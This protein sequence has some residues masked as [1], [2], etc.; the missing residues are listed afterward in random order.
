MSE[1]SEDSSSSAKSLYLPLP[2]EIVLHIITCAVPA[3]TDVLLP[4]DDPITKLLL[5]FTLVCHE[6]K[7]VAAR[8]LRQHCVVLSDQTSLSLYLLAIPQQPQLRTISS[9]SLAPF[10]ENLDDLPICSWVQELLFYTAETLTKLV[11]DMPLRSVYPEDDHLAVRS[12]LRKGFD[13]LTNLRE[14]VSCRD[15]LYLDVFDME[16]AVVWSQWLKLERL[17]L[18]NVD[19]D[20]KFWRHIARLP[21]LEI[22]ALTN[23]DSIMDTD[24]KAE[25]LKHTSRPL[26]VVTYTQPIR[27]GHYPPEYHRNDWQSIDPD[28]KVELYCLHSEFG[29]EYNSWLLMCAV[30]TA[31]ESSS[32]WSWRGKRITRPADMI[33]MC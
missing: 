7:R 3:S 31:A 13:R 22:L 24:P 12:V 21:S 20:D 23:P 27:R 1:S 30:K 2:L 10:P 17:A 32:I 11:I 14:F 18:Y 26:K 15:E 25:Y 16:G 6:T 4:P 29:E 28:T 33:G 5:A 8:S 19:A 9:L